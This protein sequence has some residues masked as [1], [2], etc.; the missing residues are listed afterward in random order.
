[1]NDSK[2]LPTILVVDDE[3]INLLLLEELLSTNDY[4]VIKAKNGWEAFDRVLEEQ[5]DLILLDILMPEMDGYDACVKLKDHPKTKEIPVIFVTSKT[6][7]VNETLG[8]EYGAVDYIRKPISP[9]VVLARVK[10]H[11]EI[12]EAKIQLQELLSKTLL[13][14][15]RILNDI[16]TFIDPAFHSMISR[17]KRYVRDISSYLDLSDRWRLELAA[18]LSHI[19]CVVIPRETLE[20]IN[21]GKVVSEVEQNMFDMHPK[22]AQDLLSKIPRLKSVAV[23]IGKQRIPVDPN[24]LMQDLSQ[25]DPVDLGGQMLKTVIDYDR[26]LTSGLSAEEAL[27]EMRGKKEGYL[28]LLLDALEAV[29]KIDRDKD[30]QQVMFRELQEGH[31]LMEDLY[32]KSGA[33]IVKKGRELTANT[34]TLLL[35]FAQTGGIK[36]PIMVKQNDII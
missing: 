1:M 14:T 7:E 5:P 13:G 4:N 10:T 6:E 8:F 26:M 16:L 30:V 19:G 15:V 29:A 9:S 34:L 11:L 35:P 12:R 33:L 20:K 22:V 31:I 27:S 28:P 3:D 23:M 36:E 21:S 25:W 2:P 32:T 18:M 24:Q 17:L